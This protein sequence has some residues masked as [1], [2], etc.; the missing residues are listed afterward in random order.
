MNY[1]RIDYKGNIQPITDDVLMDFIS[2]DIGHVLIVTGQREA[3][4]N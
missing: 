2:E 3:S 1:I 4:K